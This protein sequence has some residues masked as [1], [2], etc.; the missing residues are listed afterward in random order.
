MKVTDLIGAHLDFWVARAERFPADRLAIQL[1][2]RTNNLICVLVGA[3]HDDPLKQ[4]YDPSTNPMVAYPIIEREHIATG[5][6]GGH[7][8]TWEAY[9][10]GYS[11]YDGLEADPAYA[12]CWDAPTLLVAAMRAWVIKVFGE[13]V[14]EIDGA[15]PYPLPAPVRSRCTHKDETSRVITTAAGSEFHCDACGFMELDPNAPRALAVNQQ[16]GCR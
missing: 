12:R 6:E 4:R 13:E 7:C 11:S 10:N 15:P 3:Q 16:M 5:K 1:V 9:C 14:P 8:R 2:P